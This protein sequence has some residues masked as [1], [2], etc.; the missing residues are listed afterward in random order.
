MPPEGVDDVKPEPFAILSLSALSPLAEFD[1][2]YSEG[3]SRSGSILDVGINM[4]L[5]EKK[6]SW[7]SFETEQLGQGREQT[8]EVIQQNQE[9]QD[10]ILAKI[11]ERTKDGGIPVDAGDKDTTS[12]T[13]DE[14][15][16][17]A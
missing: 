4:G 9:L 15:A 1:I 14:P 12:P 16:A 10:R 5:I 17:E 8:K 6:G 13:A 3:I 2:Q 11:R 7:F